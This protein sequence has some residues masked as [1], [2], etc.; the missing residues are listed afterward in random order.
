MHVCLLD[1]QRFVLVRRYYI[2]L[3]A[4]SEAGAWQS[5]LWGTRTGTVWF[6]SFLTRELIPRI[7]GPG[8]Q[9]CS[10]SDTILDLA[11]S[12]GI[13]REYINLNP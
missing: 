3:D 7:K 4:M 1:V 6:S 8:I 12:F 5:L 13:L 11:L 10:R 9:K 2:C